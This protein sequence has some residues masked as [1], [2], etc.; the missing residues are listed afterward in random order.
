MPPATVNDA[1]QDVPVRAERSR[2]D[3][4]DV[5]REK[6]TH[7]ERQRKRKRENEREKESALKRRCRRD[8]E[9]RRISWI[10]GGRYVSV[11]GGGGE[12]K[13]T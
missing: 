12:G 3:D 1:S 5:S 4:E 8:Q 10:L 11:G 7:K 2:F 13:Q 9:E 6:R